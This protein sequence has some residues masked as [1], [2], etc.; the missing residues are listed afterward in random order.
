MKTK[1]YKDKNFLLLFF[2][3]LVSGIGSRLY[4][5]GISL[6]LLDLT[7][8]A[9]S[10]SSYIAIWTL[11][12]FIITPIASTFTDRWKNKVKVLFIIDFGSGIIYLII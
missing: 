12:L 3:T 1:Y 7:G 4:G 2:G 6:Y 10:M 5:F 9:T 11:V 8:L